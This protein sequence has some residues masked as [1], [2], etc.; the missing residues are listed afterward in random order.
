[1][2]KLHGLEATQFKEYCPNIFINQDLVH[3]ENDGNVVISIGDSLNI[4]EK[5][6]DEFY[7]FRY[8]PFSWV[9]YQMEKNLFSFISLN[10]WEDPFERLFYNENTNIHSSY[11]NGCVCMSYIGYRGEETP[12]KA[13]H[14]AEP[15]VKLEF[16]F[17]KFINQLSDSLMNICK[18]STC[19]ARV[20]VDVVKYAY[21]RK[22]IIDI[23][24]CKCAASNNPNLPT[25]LS[26]A[27]YLTCLSLKRKAFCNEHEIRFFLVSDKKDLDLNIP[28]FN[29]ADCVTK[30]LLPPLTPFNY[31][32]PR[33]DFYHELQDI[34][35]EG[36]KNYF[37]G[38][39]GVVNQSRLYDI[40]SDL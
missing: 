9:N 26:L 19:N 40:K 17:L 35:N 16:N 18:G 27:D 21:S 22:E 37:K 31:S 15:I 20:F 7:M 33:S 30:I 5:D 11:V 29:M 13:Y 6:S 3:E 2:E 23:Y 1:M 28:N 39:I 24:K 36:M 8:T 4:I 14:N 25:F 32:D 12:W 38:K 10:K 34:Y